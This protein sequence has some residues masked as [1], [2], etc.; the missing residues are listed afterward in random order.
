MA[1]PPDL[2]YERRLWR[3]GVGAVAGVD[4][5]GVGPLAG[6]VVAAAVVFEPEEFITGVNDSK[7]LDA[8]HRERLDGEIRA[9]AA[10]VGIGRAEPD[11]IDR[12]NIYWAALLAMRRALD[13][14]DCAPGHV[15]IDG[16][17]VPGLGVPQTRIVGG[18][19][20]SF[21][22]A[23]ASIVAKV[24]R[25]RMMVELDGRFPGY[26]FARHKGYATAEHVAALQRLGVSPIHRRSFAP[27]AEAIQI[28]LP[29]RERP[30]RAA[31]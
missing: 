14:L 22:I 6:P 21:S 27:V 19:R 4:E 25:D 11:E 15:L 20:K 23:A 30:R 29:L 16:R 3:A 26:G 7:R 10:A 5:A 18:D 17:R 28:A 2:R 31:S 13:G 24:A 1:R 8:R 12:L 9:R